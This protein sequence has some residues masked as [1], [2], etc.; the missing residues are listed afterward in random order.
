MYIYTPD[1]GILES[2]TLSAMN[3]FHLILTAS[4]FSSSSSIFKIQRYKTGTSSVAISTEERR[5][6]AKELILDV[7]QKLGRNKMLEVMK[8]IKAVDTRSTGLGQTKLLL[9]DIFRNNKEFQSRF[10]EF[11]PHQLRL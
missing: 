11:L 10:L 5:R 1:M 9:L 8:V 3:C 2:L 6:K 7:G 4:L